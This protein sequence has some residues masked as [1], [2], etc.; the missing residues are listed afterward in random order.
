MKDKSDSPDID[1]A[2]EARMVALVLGEASDFER[3]ELGRL[4]EQRPELAVLKKRLENVHELLGEVAAGEVAAGEPVAGNDAWQLSAERRKAVLSVIGGEAVEEAELVAVRGSTQRGST[5]LVDKSSESRRTVRSFL[6]GLAQVAAV[7]CLIGIAGVLTV[8]SRPRSQSATVAQPEERARQL[9]LADG[10]FSPPAG[11]ENNSA[12][13]LSA[14]RNSL[15]DYSAG[16]LNGR[17]DSASPSNDTRFSPSG[18]SNP[19]SGEFARY[20]SPDFDRE[21]AQAAREASKPSAMPG[22]DGEPSSSNTVSEDMLVPKFIESRGSRPGLA[23]QELP[24]DSK[25]LP[26]PYYTADL[27]LFTV[28]KNG[29]SKLRTPIGFP[30]PPN[31]SLGGQASMR[32]HAIRNETRLGA[33]GDGTASLS[34]SEQRVSGGPTT[35]FKSEARLSS[36]LERADGQID[37][38]KR[39][40]NE[41]AAGRYQGGDDDD[42][43]GDFGVGGLGLGSDESTITDDRKKR[44]SGRSKLNGIAFGKEGE[45]QP[46]SDADIQLLQD[47]FASSIPQLGGFEATSRAATKVGD[48]T[49]RKAQVADGRVENKVES[50]I[51]N[52]QPSP[53]SERLDLQSVDRSTVM[54]PPD[55][56]LAFADNWQDLSSSRTRAAS[57]SPGRNSTDADKSGEIAPATEPRGSAYGWDSGLELPL[58]QAP[59]GPGD[60]GDYGDSGLNGDAPI[61]FVPEFGSIILRGSER[62]VERVRRSIDSLKGFSAQLAPEESGL[63]QPEAKLAIADD[64]KASDISAFDLSIDDNSGLDPTFT[65]TGNSD[66]GP[67]KLVDSSGS[68]VPTGLDEKAADNEAFSTFSLHVSDVS[69]KLARAALALGAWPEAAKIRIEEFVNAFDYGDPL[70]SQNERVACGLEQAIHPFLQQRNVLRIAMRTATAGR[71]S[72][73][74]LRL[75]LL[76]D[77]SGSMERSDRQQTV[78][79]AFALLTQQLT[80]IDQVTLISFARRPRLLADKFNGAQSQQLLQLI[81]NLPSEGGTNIEAALKLAF[82]KAMEQQSDDAQNRIILLTDGAVNL[83]DA[84]PGNLSRMIATMRDAGI[85][86]D[87]AGISA[88]GLNDEV[89][90]ALTRQGD[91]RYYLL[92]SPEAADDGFARQ[93]AGA[94]RPSAKNVKVQVEFNPKRVGRYKLLGFENR[95]LNQEDFRDDTVDAAEMTAAEAGVALYQFEALPDGEGDVGSVSVRFRDLASGQMVE[96]LWP[97]PYQAAPPRPDQAAPSLRIAISAAMLA[98]KL[99]GEPLGETVDL[100]SLSKL[101][102]GLPQRDRQAK[103]VSELHLMIQ[104]ARQL[105]P[106]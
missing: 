95:R 76:L 94:L 105:S 96:E 60:Y 37:S 24:S 30:D 57:R 59:A 31:I 53:A 99:R 92:D 17:R 106:N 55:R 86:F 82:E 50:K 83:G 62:D 93:I 79:R 44:I 2:L 69:F 36:D 54:M 67:P 88:D 32:Q 23:E 41:A 97:I 80:P 27:P 75:T 10:E 14:L 43:D 21:W 58:S 84:N 1:L 35:A 33:P 77:N 64:T 3:E 45:G 42:S 12:S 66:R 25:A 9:I 51:A 56:P 34:D 100:K 11:D 38:I 74:P 65:F 5:Q 7:L 15:T 52:P 26:S 18:I 89:L 81:E 68:P 46:T 20:E 13:A 90:E 101:I 4:I 22:G 8:A 48:R 19:D 63:P 91:G 39:K 73:T 29:L 61:G 47:R 70:P 40:L 78:R 49:E 103:R 6:R 98:A 71:S 72:N 28:P 102:S 87:A 16:S 85:A 104:Q